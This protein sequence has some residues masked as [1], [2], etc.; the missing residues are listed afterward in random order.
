MDNAKAVTIEYDKLDLRPEDV[1]NM[2][3][4]EAFEWLEQRQIPFDHLVNLDDMRAVIRQHLE[5]GRSDEDADGTSKAK[6][7]DGTSVS[8]ND[9]MIE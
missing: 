9:Y 6:P 8:R 3:F 4:E 7:G 5:N 2:D 1:D